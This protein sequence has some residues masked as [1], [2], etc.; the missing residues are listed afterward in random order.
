M[1]NEIKMPL[2]NSEAE[3][4]LKVLPSLLSSA[5]REKKVSATST[6][7]SRRSRDVSI[8]AGNVK[9]QNCTSDLVP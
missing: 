4:D 9:E 8:H 3:E 6:P 1:L 2:I 5:Y 7:T